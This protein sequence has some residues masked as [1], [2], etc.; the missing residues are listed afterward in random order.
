MHGIPVWGVPSRGIR[1]LIAEAGS[2]LIRELN[3]QLS[4]SDLEVTLRELL[5]L[6]RDNGYYTEYLQ[7]RK[8]I[9]N[10][11]GSAWARLSKTCQ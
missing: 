11:I 10:E 5:A 7:L 6:K 8:E 4:T 9:V 1:E 2:V 3:V